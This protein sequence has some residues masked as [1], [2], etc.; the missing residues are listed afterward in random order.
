MDHNP[1]NGRDAI[2]G[3]RNTMRTQDRWSG[4]KAASVQLGHNR[5]VFRVESLHA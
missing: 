4:T 3:G 5:H 1:D 2:K